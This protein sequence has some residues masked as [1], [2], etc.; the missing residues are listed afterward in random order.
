MTFV[1]GFSRN[2]VRSLETNGPRDP[3]VDQ[4]RH[5][6]SGKNQAPWALVNPRGW[7]G[8]LGGWVGV[9]VLGL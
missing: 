7:V 9:G 1:S 2:G 4:G 6:F 3:Q 5:R 8:R